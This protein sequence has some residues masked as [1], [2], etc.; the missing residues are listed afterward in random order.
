[1]QRRLRT[2]AEQRYIADR[3]LTGRFNVEGGAI[4]YE[5][6]ETI[7]SD[8]SPLAV[9]PGAEYPLVGLTSRHRVA[10]EGR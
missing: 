10:G 3:I 5:T 7:F 1:V 8:D 2:L 9:A 6:G 4:L